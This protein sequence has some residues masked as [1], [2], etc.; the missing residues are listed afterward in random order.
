VSAEKKKSAALC[1]LVLLCCLV[2]AAVDGAQVDYA[3]KS[4][5]KLALFLLAPLLFARLCGTL[6]LKS[7]FAAGK[8][9][10]LSA[11]LLGAAVYALILGGYF[12]LRGVFDFSAVTSA[13]TGNIGVTGENF[14]FVALYISFVNSLLEEFF[15]R[16]FAF[17]T[18][19]KLASRRCAYAF[20]A[21]AFALYHVAMML[22]WFGWGLF[23]LLLA[24]LFVG[25]LLFNALVE[26]GGSIYPSWLVHMCAN[27]AINTVGF[28]LFGVV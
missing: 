26:R 10:L 23:A 13:L 8:R 9:Q 14:L 16:G 27:F 11:L 24:G 3:P 18:L 19:K 1:T 7:L 6:Q 28:V 20:S 21:L 22:G 17:L 25:G 2:M 4:A 5:V 12:L 15:F